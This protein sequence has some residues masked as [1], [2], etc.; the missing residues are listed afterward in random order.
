[1]F[2]T[3]FSSFWVMLDAIGRI[4]LIIIAAGILV[5]LKVITQENIKSMAT[6]TV[7]ILLPCLLFG[8]INT[9]F[10]PGAFHNWWLLP[11]SCVAMITFGLGLGYLFYPKSFHEKQYLF[12]LASMQNAIYLVLPIGRFVFPEQFD[13][14]ALYNFLFIIGFT[15]MAW[16]IGKVMITGRSFKTVRFSE[17]ITPPFVAAI[18]SVLLVMV[19]LN[20]YI[21]TLVLDSVSLVGEATIP[22]SNIVLGA[23]LGGISLKV[24]PKIS[25]LLKVTTIKFVLIPIFTIMVLHFIGLKNAN[26][27]LAN[28]LVIESAAAPAT[29]LILQVR[30]YGGD[31]QTIGSIMLIS[32]ALCLF[33]IPFWMAVWQFF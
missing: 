25:D 4:F 33:T 9:T 2:E 23:T 14:F 17:F 27:L 3:F 21:P 20:K 28:M 12:P 1:M 5:R 19:G 15:P 10:D 18:G 6:I 31:K 29:A 24:W 8:N 11:L 26:P 22:V 7:N 32:Y 16:S 13:E 30:S